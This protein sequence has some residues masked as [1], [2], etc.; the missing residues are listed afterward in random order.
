M[1]SWIGGFLPPLLEEYPLAEEA[2]NQAAAL[3]ASDVDS[4]S[5][6]Y[7]LT[8]KTTSKSWKPTKKTTVEDETDYLVACHMT[9]VL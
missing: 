4:N 3:I 1:V 5:P 7:S 8:R 9:V 6:P 2:A